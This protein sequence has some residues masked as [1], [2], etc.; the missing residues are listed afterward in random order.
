M[1]SWVGSHWNSMTLNHNTNVERS[2]SFHRLSNECL[3]HL[4]MFWTNCTLRFHETMLNAFFI[5][6]AH[7][8]NTMRSIQL[9][10]FRFSTLYRVNA[11][12]FQSVSTCSVLQFEYFLEINGFHCPIKHIEAN[13]ELNLN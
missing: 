2:I 10:T 3:N 7:D 12:R 11:L 1:H 8:F 4:N 9:M 13:T 6:R 5:N